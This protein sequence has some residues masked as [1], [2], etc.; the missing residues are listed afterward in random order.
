MVVR[1]SDRPQDYRSLTV[2]SLVQI[3]D[4]QR[5]PEYTE[6]LRRM[7]RTVGKHSPRVPVNVADDPDVQALVR[8][9]KGLA[10]NSERQRRE[11][12]AAVRE[13]RGLAEARAA[14]AT[15]S[16]DHMHWYGIS[17]GLAMAERL[18]TA[19]DDS[20]GEQEQ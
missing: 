18:I 2:A 13:L 16:S 7:G 11:L 8:A 4:E 15:E 14:V 19:S 6:A 3:P 12:L 1:W 20:Q 5:L 9:A 17:E 10:E